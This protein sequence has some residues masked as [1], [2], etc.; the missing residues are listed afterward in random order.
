MKYFRGVEDYQGGHWGMFVKPINEWRKTAMNW[1]DSDENWEI[2]NE[3]KYYRIKNKD[4]IPFIERMWDIKIVETPKE[5]YLKY[6]DVLYA[7]DY[8]N[9]YWNY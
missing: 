7:E 3:L 2:Y 8:E 5:M 9:D 6:K 1:C 4:L